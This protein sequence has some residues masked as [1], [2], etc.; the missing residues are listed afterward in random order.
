MKQTIGY[1]L[2]SS[3]TST[4]KLQDTIIFHASGHKS[5]QGEIWRVNRNHGE[6]FDPRVIMSA[7]AKAHS[8]I[9]K[10]VAVDQGNLVTIIF[11]AIDSLHESNIIVKSLVCDQAPIN[12]SLFKKLNI[13]GS[14]PYFS[15]NNCIIHCMYN[16]PHLLKSLRNNMLKSD[17]I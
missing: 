12:Q 10:A 1:Y 5:S 9:R 16:F 17:K 4:V 7:M 14:Q 2:F 13:T 3:K 6:G 11:H 15:R 8:E